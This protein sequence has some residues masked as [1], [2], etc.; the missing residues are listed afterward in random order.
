MGQS[1]NDKMY[2]QHLNHDLLDALRDT[3]L[4]ML[5]SESRSKKGIFSYDSSSNSLNK[6]VQ[7]DK[8]L[9]GDLMAFQMENTPEWM[10][11]TA[12][13]MARKAIEHSNLNYADRVDC[14]HQLMSYHQHYKK[15][16]TENPN[17]SF[18]E[19]I[20]MA[21]NAR[22]YMYHTLLEFG[23]VNT[24][25][26]FNQLRNSTLMWRLFDR[27][28]IDTQLKFLDDKTVH[29]HSEKWENA[30]PE[31][32]TLLAQFSSEEYTKMSQPDKIIKSVQQSL[33][34]NDDPKR[35]T[36]GSQERDWYTPNAQVTSY[37]CNNGFSFQCW[38]NG[39]LRTKTDFYSNELKQ[40]LLSLN[41]KQ[42]V[43]NATGIDF[44]SG[45]KKQYDAFCQ[46]YDVY[47]ESVQLEPICVSDECQS[48]V[49]KNKWIFSKQ[50]LEPVKTMIQDKLQEE[51]QNIREREKHIHMLNHTL[52]KLT[53]YENFLVSINTPLAVHGRMLFTHKDEIKPSLSLIASRL[54]K[55]YGTVLRLDDQSAATSDFT[56]ELNVY[57]DDPDSVDF[58]NLTVFFENIHRRACELL[59]ED[60]VDQ[61]QVKKVLF[62]SCALHDT[63]RH[64][65]HYHNSTYNSPQKVLNFTS[66]LLASTALFNDASLLN[67][68]C[69]S[70]KDRTGVMLAQTQTAFDFWSDPRNFSTG[71]P[72]LTDS[73]DCESDRNL[74]HIKTLLFSG[75]WPTAV[76]QDCQ[77]AA[78]KS[79]GAP[80]DDENS[81]LDKTLNTIGD[82]ALSQKQRSYLS[83]EFLNYHRH[84]SE[85][86][87]DFHLKCMKKE[88]TYAKIS[89]LFRKFNPFYASSLSPSIN[90]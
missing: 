32:D 53:G 80:V 90:K 24:R 34:K 7:A 30:F 40:K 3:R 82:G 43:Y 12:L 33:I 10:G 22:E 41:L 79:L 38:T 72:T 86:N 49:S 76:A 20:A 70:G 36:S 87:G 61:T 55:N 42:F 37:S 4:F 45:S 28:N 29:I 66:N 78:L 68:K 17:L 1:F 5:N 8:V 15:V 54:L 48:Y 50:P 25:S 2:Y 67:I 31:Q 88:S 74:S 23:I 19:K 65:H 63:L 44:S 51:D 16:Y 73:C 75:H 11:I 46:S 57:I 56:D 64:W 83:K 52:L 81:L 77:C 84:R 89:A 85:Y 9:D 69:K 58:S 21:D 27:M 39:D 59:R 62:S 26:D 14:V 71:L 18:D 35:L 6:T 47:G 13:E 60:G